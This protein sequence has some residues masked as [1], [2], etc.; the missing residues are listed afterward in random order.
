[1][2]TGGAAP[3]RLIP[4]GGVATALTATGHVAGEIYVSSDMQLC[5][6][7]GTTWYQVVLAPVGRGTPPAAAPRAP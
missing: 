1:M 7:D 3:L 4:G 5:F 6:F 2:F